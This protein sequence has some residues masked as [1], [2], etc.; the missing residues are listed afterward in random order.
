MLVRQ[1]FQVLQN[2]S[3]GEGDSRRFMSQLRGKE[4]SEVASTLRA[5]DEKIFTLAVIAK[6]LGVSKA[7]AYRLA[8]KGSRSNA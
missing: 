4:L 8:P 3:I 5:R 7:T 1:A 2:V 6:L